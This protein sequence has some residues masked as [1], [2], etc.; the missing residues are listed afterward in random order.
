MLLPDAVCAEPDSLTG[1]AWNPSFSETG[2]VREYGERPILF[3]DRYE[4]REV[5]VLASRLVAATLQTRSRGE[6]VNQMG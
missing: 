3:M 4:Q 6:K 5:D 1:Y 2:R